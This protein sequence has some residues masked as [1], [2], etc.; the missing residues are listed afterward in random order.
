M[1]VRLYQHHAQAS[2]VAS[3]YSKKV[4]RWIATTPMSLISLDPNIS[5]NSKNFPI[6][7]KLAPATL[8]SDNS[9]INTY[10][11][12]RDEQ[13]CLH[14]CDSSKCYHS[15]VVNIS[16]WKKQIRALNNQNLS[17]FHLTALHIAA[18]HVETFHMIIFYV[19]PLHSAASYVAFYCVVAFHLL[20][21]IPYRQHRGTHQMP[22]IEKVIIQIRLDF[23]IQIW[24]LYRSVKIYYI[25]FRSGQIL[26][27]IIK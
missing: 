9:T 16:K 1:P 27:D 15:L 18:F 14:S 23:I 12:R 17:T 25:D 2:Y 8:A 7:L 13:L 6:I 11:K 21:I 10:A 24:L 22:M 19:T 4:M 20:A 3:T 5:Q 26:F